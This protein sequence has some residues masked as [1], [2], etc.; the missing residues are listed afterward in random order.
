MHAKRLHL[1]TPFR[2]TDRPSPEQS[3]VSLWMRTVAVPTW[4]L[5]PSSTRVTFAIGQYHVPAAAGAVTASTTTA[6]VSPRL[7]PAD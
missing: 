3:V 2:R 7:T 1:L 6:S 5:V 4:T